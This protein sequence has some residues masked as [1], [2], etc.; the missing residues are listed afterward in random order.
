[1]LCCAGFE[2]YYNNVLEIYCSPMLLVHWTDKD[3]AT[4]HTSVTIFMC[5][6]FFVCYAGNVDELLYLVFWALTVE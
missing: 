2:I 6:C 3:T 4:V 5:L 1:M